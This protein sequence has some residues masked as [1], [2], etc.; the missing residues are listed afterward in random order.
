MKEKLFTSKNVTY[1]AVLLAFVIVLQL[2]GSYIKIGATTFSF[3]LVPIVLGGILLGPV[4]GMILGFA[5]GLTVLLMGVF[6][7]DGFTMILFNDSP[8]ITTLICLV[9]GV[10]AGVVPAFVY[11]WISK[12]NKYV[13]VF[14][15]SA[16]AP[17]VNTGLFIIGALFLSSTLQA[18]FLQDGTS[19]I[20]FL[21]IVCAGVNF[22]VELA[23]N[24]VLAPAVYRV[25]EVVNKFRK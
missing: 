25:A 5:F 12:K 11:R 15:A 14:V 2:F 18:N 8:I 10:A 19:V 17:I 21:V 7:V 22:L 6:A 23:I 4:F 16:T 20:Y 9:K 3:V 24:L 13:A 1:L